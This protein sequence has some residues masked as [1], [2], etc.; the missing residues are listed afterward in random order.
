MSDDRWLAALREE[1]LRGGVRDDVAVLLRVRYRA[2]RR[3]N[4]YLEAP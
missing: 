3:V 2:D 4:R 1:L